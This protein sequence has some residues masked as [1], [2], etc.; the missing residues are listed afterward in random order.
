[1]NLPDHLVRNGVSTEHA[2][3][4]PDSIPAGAAPITRGRPRD[5]EFDQR[6]LAA[7]LDELSRSGI[8]HFSVAAVA[9]RAGVAKGSVYLRWP[10][11]EQLIHDCATQIAAS[12]PRLEGESFFEDLRQL[13]DHFAARW[14]RPHTIEMLLRVDAEREEHPELFERIF[15]HTQQAGSLLVAQV[16]TDAQARGEINQHVSAT[17]ISRIFVGALLVEALAHNPAG[18]VSSDFRADLLEFVVNAIGT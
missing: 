17:L 16:V 9:R 1:M 11:R 8:S 2:A 15:E 5:E 7:G 10:T 4:Q 6:I 13:A 3:A 18:H 12:V 14:D